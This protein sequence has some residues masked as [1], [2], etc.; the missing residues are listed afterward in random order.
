[1]IEKDDIVFDG[2]NFTIYGN[3]DFESKGVTLQERLNVTIKNLK[4]AAF[5]YGIWLSKSQNNKLITNTIYTMHRSEHST[6]KLK[7]QHYPRKSNVRKSGT[8]NPVC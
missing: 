2:Q 1:M 8:R 6:L 3:I 7:Q 4:I 5:Y